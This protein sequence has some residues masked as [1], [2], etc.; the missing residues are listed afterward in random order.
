MYYE[1][2]TLINADGTGKQAALVF[3]DFVGAPCVRPQAGR[4]V[5]I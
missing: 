3:V 5:S 4:M 1:E 2:H